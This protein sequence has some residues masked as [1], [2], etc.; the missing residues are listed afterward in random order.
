MRYLPPVRWYGVAPGTVVV[1]NNGVPRTVL[2]NDPAPTLGHRIVLIEGLA[3]PIYIRDYQFAAPV[4]LD[5]SDAVATLFTS[6]FTVTPIER[7]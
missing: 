4:E 1:D 2:A 3:E 5:E 7:N 6:G